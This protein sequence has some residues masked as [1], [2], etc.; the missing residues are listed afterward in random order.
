MA[1]GCIAAA[2]AIGI[3]TVIAL[4]ALVLAACFA[5]WIGINV[6]FLAPVWRDLNSG[7]VSSVEGLVKGQEKETDIKTGPMTSFPIWSYCWTVDGRDRFWVSGKAYAVLM[8]ARHRLYFLPISRRIVGI[9]PLAV[10]TP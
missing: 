6:W 1:A 8:P 3:T 2:L 5:V 4:G 9:E 10:Q 7:I